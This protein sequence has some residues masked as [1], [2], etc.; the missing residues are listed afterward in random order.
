MFRIFRLL[1]VF[2]LA[3][4]WHTFNYFL[5]TIQHSIVKIGSFSVLLVLIIFTFTV[6][7]MQLFSYQ[8]K[9]NEKNEAVNYFSPKIPQQVYTYPDSN[10]NNFLNGFIS[11]FI[12]IAG[13]GW[14]TIYLDHYRYG[15]QNGEPY[16]ASIFFISL[17]ILGQTI[18]MNLFLSI[19]LKEFDE[20]A[21]IVAEEKK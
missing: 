12:V 2:K 21:L 4:K 1:R 9:F 16:T 14:L 15:V 20:R 5:N 6:L 17:V 11:V 7:G 3:R 19:L 8:L 18:L 13:D 10:F